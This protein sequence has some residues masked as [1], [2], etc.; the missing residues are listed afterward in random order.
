MRFF[1][2][3]SSSCV[4]LFGLLWGPFQYYQVFFLP[5]TWVSQG[6]AFPHNFFV[7]VGR[8][9]D[10]NYTRFIDTRTAGLRALLTG[11]SSRVFVNLG[12]TCFYKAVTLVSHQSDDL[13][14]A[15]AREII[16]Y[17]IGDIA[18]SRSIFVASIQGVKLVFKHSRV[19][20]SNPLTKN[21]KKF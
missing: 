14:A 20:G 16:S 21:K 17:R 7:E 15:V 11:F 6:T 18:V 8:H 13:A 2:L 4:P 10:N 1:I 12:G 9:Y 3:R 19:P 5:S